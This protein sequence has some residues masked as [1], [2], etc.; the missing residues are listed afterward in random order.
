MAWCLLETTWMPLMSAWNY[1][2]STWYYFFSYDQSEEVLKFEKSKKSTKS[3]QKYPTIIE[4]WIEQVGFTCTSVYKCPQVAQDYYL[5][6][7]FDL[8]EVSQVG[9][10]S[11]NQNWVFLM[12]HLLAPS[13]GRQ[14]HICLLL[15]RNNRSI[16]YFKG[17]TVPI[18][19]QFHTD[20]AFQDHFKTWLCQVS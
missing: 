16:R 15:H 4:T 14:S 18:Y 1:L 13:N 8:L 9:K 6:F 2:I 3:T 7:T 11:F 10:S 5:K 12:Y 20:K 17:F 19:T